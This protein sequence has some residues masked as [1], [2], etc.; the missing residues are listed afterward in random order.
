VD[1]ISYAAANAAKQ[2]NTALQSR[3][4]FIADKNNRRIFHDDG[5]LTGNWMAE[6]SAGAWSVLP[7][8]IPGAGGA[9]INYTGTPGAVKL[10]AKPEAGQ[11]NT[12]AFL[13]PPRHRKWFASSEILLSASGACSMRLQHGSSLVAGIRLGVGAAGNVET[14]TGDGSSWVNVTSKL[15]GWV[16]TGVY[17]R[18]LVVIDPVAMKAFFFAYY[19]NTTSV[20][21]GLHVFLGERTITEELLS[22]TYV[23]ESGNSTNQ[24]IQVKATRIYELFMV[25]NGCSTDQVYTHYDISPNVERASN[26]REV[27]SNGPLALS[28][29]L[30][31]DRDWPLNHAHGGYLVKEML[32]DFPN[33]VAL[34]TP[35]IVTLGSATNSVGAVINGTTTMKTIQ[36]EYLAMVEAALAI[37]TDGFGTPP[38][39]MATTISPRHDEPNFVTVAHREL[40]QEFNNWMRTMLP[41]KSII[42]RDVWAALVGP[43]LKLVEWADDG[44]HLHWSTRAVQVTTDIGFH[45]LLKTLATA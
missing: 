34:L 2:A 3:L 36:E 37:N 31:G 14:F 41:S 38:V 23:I 25:S 43:E 8:N 35:R 6:A 39:V 24:T 22:L 18:L 30:N 32:E 16:Q 4:A 15:P 20:N 26:L 10:T 11:F 19:T 1:V 42:I 29:R 21:L 40:L 12:A 27:Q 7:E 33:F 44:T 9:I 5:N 28:Y 17:I 45:A 13:R